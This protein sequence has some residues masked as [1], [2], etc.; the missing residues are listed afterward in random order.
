MFDSFNVELTNKRADLC[1][2]Y[3]KIYMHH[4]CGLI[5]N[6]LPIYR[7][8]RVDGV[9]AFTPPPIGDVRYTEGRKLLGPEYSMISGLASGL[10][11]MDKDVICRQVADHFEDARTAGNVVFCVGGAHLTFSAMELIFTEAQKMKGVS[12][13]SKATR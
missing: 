1:H 9:D 5:R 8:T 7:K 13:Q 4:S 12:G 6:L 2:A 10:S 11:S 3:G